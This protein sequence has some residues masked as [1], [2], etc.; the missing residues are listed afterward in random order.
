M[1]PPYSNPHI[2]DPTP[3][4]RNH[5][6]SASLPPRNFSRQQQPAFQPNM[7]QN[8][9]FQPQG[10]PQ[11]THPPSYPPS[12]FPSSQSSNLQQ[13]SQPQTFPPLLPNQPNQLSFASAQS[14]LQFFND[15]GFGTDMTRRPLQTSFNNLPLPGLNTI[16]AGSLPGLNQP[17]GSI[18]SLQNPFDDETPLLQELGIDF[19]FIMRKTKAILTVFRPL[20]PELANDNDLAGPLVFCLLLGFLLLLHGK[21]HFGYIYGFGLMGSL[22]MYFILNLMSPTAIS[23]DMTCSVLGYSLLPIVFLVINLIFNLIIK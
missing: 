11:P 19:P 10:Q 23:F 15:T 18:D 22:M 5:M 3:N 12:Q 4:P 6:Q 21:I 9:F 8:T 14:E 2:A 20:S 16:G 1:Q 7:P 13:S 17:M